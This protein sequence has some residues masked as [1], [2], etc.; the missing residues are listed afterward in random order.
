M[1]VWVKGVCASEWDPAPG[2]LEAHSEVTLSVCVHLLFCSGFS[3]LTH[4]FK[5]PVSD[6][7]Q[8]RRILI[9]SSS[10]LAE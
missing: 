7:I 1:S 9:C 5:P 8:S 2:L 4:W 6:A 10:S 3:V